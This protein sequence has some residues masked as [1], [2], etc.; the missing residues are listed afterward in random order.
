VIGIKGNFLD[1]LFD[2][3]HLG[4]VTLDTSVSNLRGQVVQIGSVFNLSQTQTKKPQQYEKRQSF[5]KSD[6]VKSSSFGKNKP[7]ND[8]RL[9]DEI[10]EYDQMRKSSKVRSFERIPMRDLKKKKPTYVEKLDN[11]YKEGDKDEY[12]TS[13]KFSKVENIEDTNYRT[14]KEYFDTQRYNTPPKLY[15]YNPLELLNNSPVPPGNEYMIYPYIAMPAPNPTSLPITF[16]GSYPMMNIPDNNI[17][18]EFIPDNNGEPKEF[19]L[20]TSGETFKSKEG[21]SKFRLNTSGDIYNSKDDSEKLSFLKSGESTEEKILKN[22]S[23]DS[24]LTVSD[25]IEKDKQKKNLEDQTT[26]TTPLFYNP[27]T[28]KVEESSPSKEEKNPEVLFYSHNNRT[29]KKK[30]VKQ[31]KENLL[32]SKKTAHLITMMARTRF[33]FSCNWWQKFN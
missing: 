26:L 8:D 15:Y 19:R 5:I 23:E 27:E 1:I 6:R 33:K 13:P 32:G 14:Y 12:K 20:N 3:P 28:P 11:E 2:Y 24:K 25:E 16:F 9:E 22:S 4:G 21:N 30:E 17:R 7:Q 31:A 18:Q 29:G 10:Y